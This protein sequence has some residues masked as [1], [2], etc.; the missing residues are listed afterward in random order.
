MLAARAAPAA[1]P[2]GAVYVTTLPSGAD[3]WMDGTY[4]GRAPVL[5]DA[6][7]PGHHALTITKTGWIVREVDVTVAEGSVTM[8]STRLQAGPYALAG[9]A[10]GAALFRGVP[11]GAS[12]SLDGAPLKSVA[13]PVSLPA[14]P[15]HVVMTTAHGRTT[16]SFSVL[17]DTTTDVVLR[18]P[19]AGDTH[20]ASAVLASAE[21]YLPTDDF[22][23]QGTKIV[24]R[25]AGHVVVAHF[26]EAAVRF[27]GVTIVYDSMPQ[28]IGGKLY[29]P[30]PLLEKLAEDTSKDP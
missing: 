12:L 25:Y 10:A 1:E 24:L 19:A 2:S 15:H 27:D 23:V 30:L 20:G 22:S 16:L 26:G 11:S 13:N 17:P 4:V 3:V 14:G 18:E 9:S 29:L 5:V 28:T 7:V 21:D 6:L 8:S